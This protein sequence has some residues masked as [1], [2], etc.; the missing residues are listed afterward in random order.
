MLYC[1]YYFIKNVQ[2]Y[3]HVLLLF[4]NVVRGDFFGGWA[5][6]VWLISTGRLKYAIIQSLVQVLSC[7]YG[8]SFSLCSNPATL[9]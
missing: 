1:C 8:P 9:I 3:K 4:S 7:K 2:L 6:E 5:N